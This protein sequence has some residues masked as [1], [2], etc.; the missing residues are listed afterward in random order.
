MNKPYGYI[1]KIACKVNGKL[2]IGQTIRSIKDN[3]RPIMCIENNTAY[4]S[5]K[6]AALSLGISAHS[7][8]KYLAGKLKTAQGFTLI[9]I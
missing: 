8:G 6:K 7:S 5:I 3:Q 2:Y 1:Y 4:L 9:Y